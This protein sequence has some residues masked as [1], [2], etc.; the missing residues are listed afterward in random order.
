MS[1]KD[2]TSRNIKLRDRRIGSS[3]F[4]L[5]SLTAAAPIVESYEQRARSE[6]LKC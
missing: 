2:Y 6:S 3:T 4:A 1:K 5:D